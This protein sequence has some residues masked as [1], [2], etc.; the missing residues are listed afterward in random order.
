M[1]TLSILCASLLVAGTLM[2]QT[3]SSTGKGQPVTPAVGQP[4]PAPNTK[5]GISPVKPTPGISPV[6]QPKV[7]PPPPAKP[8]GISP[9][10]PV[11]TV[12]AKPITIGPGK[13]VMVP[14]KPTP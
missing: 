6:N 11:S 8:V 3:P 9:T 4:A 13:P 7:T 12:P 1:K 5:P 2:A 10:K 14:T